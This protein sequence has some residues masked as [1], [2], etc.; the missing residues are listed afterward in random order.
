MSGDT[1]DEK[2]VV[3]YTTASVVR[4]AAAGE[5]TPDELMKLIRQRAKDPTIFDEGVVPFTWSA[6]VSNSTLDTYFTRQDTQSLKNYAK[7]AN[8]GVMFLDS[9]DKR[10]LG[11]GQS[12]RGTFTP[13]SE[14]VNERTPND[15]DPATVDVDFFTIPGMRLGRADSDSFIAGVRSGVIHD[16][17]ISFM[18]D[19][20]ECNF[21]RQ[22]PFDWWSMECMHIPGAYYDSTGNKIVKKR[23]EGGTQAFAWVRDSRL[24]EVSAVYDGATT[25]A[26][27]KKAQ[28]LAEAGE[29]DRVAAGII[30]RQLRI[31]LPKKAMYTPILK[32]RDGKMFLDRGDEV[33]IDGVRYNE[34]MEIMPKT[35]RRLSDARGTQDDDPPGEEEK[36]LTSPPQNPNLKRDESPEGIA[37]SSG[38][39]T[40]PAHARPEDLRMNEEQVRAL[41][42][43]ASRDADMVNRARRALGVFAIKDAETVDLE[44]AIARLC[45][46]VVDLSPRAKLGDEWRDRVVSEALDAGVRSDKNFDRDGYE[47]TFRHM[48]I[49]Q[50]ER[51]AAVWDDKAPKLGGRRTADV[52][53]DPPSS[54]TDATEVSPPPAQFS[55]SGRNGRR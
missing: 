27:I 12:L 10:Q 21:C 30:E 26:Y 11:F 19:R 28:W 16:V 7:N 24:L 32:I 3:H 17:S 40:S 43:Q 53:N 38:G 1:A 20:F 33:I 23:D 34:G 47:E 46:Q 2:Q 6:Q 51:I 52:G 29:V 5:A 35:F 9:H 31:H 14:K 25:G 15:N 42:E 13:S 18:P 54:K 55:V 8:E 4:A 41:Q 50:I 45:E 48:T 22:D 36:P 39:I 44:S 37:D 49:P